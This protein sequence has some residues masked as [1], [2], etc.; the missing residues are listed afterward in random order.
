MLQDHNQ[1]VM[2]TWFWAWI[3]PATYNYWCHKG[4][5]HQ[6]A[7]CS[8]PKIP[9]TF[10]LEIVQVAMLVMRLKWDPIEWRLTNPRSNSARWDVIVNLGPIKVFFFFFFLVRHSPHLLRFFHLQG[11]SYEE[12]AQHC[13]HPLAQKLLSTMAAKRSNLCV[14][15]DFV[16]A[17]DILRVSQNSLLLLQCISL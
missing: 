5:I 14:A 17:A 3:L 12:R 16:K 11:L 9:S 4:G 2:A 10:W 13:H 1:I 15:A 7:I 8:C 6:M